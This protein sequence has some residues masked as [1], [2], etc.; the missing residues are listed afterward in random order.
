MRRY[1]SPLRSC[2]RLAGIHRPIPFP[3]RV[4]TTVP[5][6]KLCFSGR[7]IRGKPDFKGFKN[8][9]H[10]KSGLKQQLIWLH[11]SEPKGEKGMQLESAGECFWC[12]QTGHWKNKW[13]KAILSCLQSYRHTVTQE[14]FSRT[15]SNLQP[16][17]FNNPFLSSSCIAGTTMQRNHILEYA[18]LQSCN[19][20]VRLWSYP[21]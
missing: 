1:A 5:N 2:T 15:S 7:K 12:G 8:R 14:H 17:T 18:A 20:S 13:D 6:S 21:C 16:E 19:A 4:S 9:R 10:N 11:P 3:P